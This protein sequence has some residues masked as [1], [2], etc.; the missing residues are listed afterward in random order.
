MTNV[1]AF[2][3]S[4]GVAHWQFIAFRHNEHQIKDAKELSVRLGFADFLIRRTNRFFDA[5]TGTIGS[6]PVFTRSGDFEYFIEAPSDPRWQNPAASELVNIIGS[7]ASYEA[8]LDQAS[9]SCKAASA[10]S[11]FVSAEGLVFPCP[12]LGHIYVRG[13]PTEEHEV[14]KLLES[15]GGLQCL[16]AKVRSIREILSDVFFQEKVPGAWRKPSLR[17]GKLRVCSHVC[18][19]TEDMFARANVWLQAT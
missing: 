1:S 8:L 7:G 12:Y 5:E 10:S 19:G 11:I 9:I 6:Y 3:A 13:E 2:I 17:E 4:G 16:N 18:G 14:V 15:S